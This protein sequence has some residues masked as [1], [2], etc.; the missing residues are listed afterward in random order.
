MNRDLVTYAAD[1]AVGHGFVGDDGTV[2][3]P[4]GW[5]GQ[6][7]LSISKDEGLTWDQVQV[8]ENGA[9]G[10]EAGIAADGKGNL[11]YTWIGGDDLPYFAISRNGGKKWS[12]PLMVGAPGVN[13]VTLPTLDVGDPG[14]IAIAYMGSENSR[15][16]KCAPDCSQGDYAGVKWNGY[17]TM[18][19]DLFSKNPVFYS[20]NVNNE[21]DPMAL[22]AC[23]P[24]R[25]YE[26]Y[27]FIDVVVGFDGSPASDVALSRA[28]ARVG[29]TGK[30]Y[31]VHA[32]DVP[33]A[34]RGRGTLDVQP[35]RRSSGLLALTRQSYVMTVSGPS[36]SKT[37]VPVP[38]RSPVARMAKPLA[39]GLGIRRKPDPG[40]LVVF[41]ASGDLTS[42]LLMPAVAQLAQA[43]LLPPGLTIVGLAGSAVL[44]ARERVRAKTRTVP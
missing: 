20:G 17:M 34:W 3:L 7:F 25:C 18:T 22:G 10:H 30:L 44:E 14:K 21:V 2:Y 41:G 40:A 11:Y 19:A 31:L 9:K 24:R 37:H 23:G 36:C 26:A 12:K 5:C 32:W 35:R 28:I 33:E 4:R 42:R 29:T 38:S 16:A 15:Y 13:E 27:D 8:A 1:G 39:A 6:P 43:Q